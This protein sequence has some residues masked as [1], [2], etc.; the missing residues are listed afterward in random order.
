MT[1]SQK[2]AGTTDCGCTPASE[3]RLEDLVPVAVV[4]A[5]GCEPCAERMVRRA[6]DRGCSPREVRKTLAIVADMRRQECLAS[7]VG[8]EVL[9]RMDRP[10]A[11]GR[12]TLQATIG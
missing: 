3:P 11:R 6:L 8:A 4:I 1:Q 12:Q 5:A 9:G 2:T 10:L 7:A